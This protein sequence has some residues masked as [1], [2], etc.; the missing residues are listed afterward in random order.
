VIT[1]PLCY[2]ATVERQ[3]EESTSQKTQLDVQC[4]ELRRQVTDLK[5]TL[6]NETQTW[7]TDRTSLS[8]QLELVLTH[9]F[10]MYFLL[11]LYSILKHLL[12]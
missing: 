8:Q 7:E 6:V 4:S 12:T 3:A 11:V 10:L 1:R 9:T 2:Q 5:E